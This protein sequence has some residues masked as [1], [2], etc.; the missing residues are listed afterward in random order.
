[1]K[2]LFLIATIGRAAALA[3]E[4]NQTFDWWVPLYTDDIR[5]GFKWEVWRWLRVC[6]CL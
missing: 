5:H 6:V 3:G 1:M 4:L 2:E